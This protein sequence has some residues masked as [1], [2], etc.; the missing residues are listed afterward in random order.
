[1]NA[2]VR[3]YIPNPNGNVQVFERH[4]N[5]VSILEHHHVDQAA[6]NIE[7]WDGLVEAIPQP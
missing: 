1:L 5:E 3:T 2:A 4:R 7:A 6:V